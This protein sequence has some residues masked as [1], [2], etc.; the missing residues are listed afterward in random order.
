MLLPSPLLPSVSSCFI[1]NGPYGEEHRL[2]SSLVPSLISVQPPGTVG[3][4]LLCVGHSSTFIVLSGLFPQLDKMFLE[5]RDGSWISHFQPLPQRLVL[6]HSVTYQ[7]LVEGCSRRKYWE[8]RAE[9][10]VAPASVLQGRGLE[11]RDTCSSHSF[12]CM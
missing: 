10:D 12:I 6:S 3:H 2:P 9:H 8:H 4:S 5:S 11:R 1:R 7:I